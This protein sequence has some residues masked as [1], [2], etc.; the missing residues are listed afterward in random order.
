MKLAHYVMLELFLRSGQPSV[1]DPLVPVPLEEVLATEARPHDDLAHTVV[2]SPKKSGINVELTTTDSDDGPLTVL[3]Y[4]F[5][6][7]RQTNAF[8]KRLRLE[9]PPAELAQLHRELSSRLDARCNFFFRLDLTSLARG[10]WRLVKR[11]PCVQVK[12]S[13]A[14]YPKNPTTARTTVERILDGT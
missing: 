3:R 8:F 10:E 12:V 1:L 9:L 13:V 14:A 6:K 7:A 4:F 11:G 5:R 2:H